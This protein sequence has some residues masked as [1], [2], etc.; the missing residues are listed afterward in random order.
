M[1]EIQA[2]G[3]KKEHETQDDE[4][5][6]VHSGTRG[7]ALVE[8]PDVVVATGEENTMVVGTKDEIEAYVEARGIVFPKPSRG[9]NRS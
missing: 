7:I 1:T 9:R 6:V 4:Y 3:N 8:D 2:V 5:C